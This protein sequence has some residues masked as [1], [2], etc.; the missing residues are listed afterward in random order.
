[1]ILELLDAHSL[2]RF[3]LKAVLNEIGHHISLCL[4]ACLFKVEDIDVPLANFLS[5]SWK[6]FATDQHIENGSETPDIDFLISPSIIHPYL[7]CIEDVI[8]PADLLGQFCTSLSVNQLHRSD[9]GYDK[10][11][12]LLVTEA[13]R[14]SNMHRA[15]KFV[16][17]SLAVE[18]LKTFEKL[19]GDLSDF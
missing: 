3:Y 17:H 10:F 13:G 4:P 18:I 15:E 19:I 5:L 2:L 9:V 7:W 16:D 1:M 12:R 6:Y 8:Q 11:D 14:H